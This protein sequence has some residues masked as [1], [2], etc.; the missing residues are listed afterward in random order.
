MA[1]RAAPAAADRDRGYKR[2]L[3]ARYG[4]REYWI[5][6]PQGEMVEV[7]TLVAALPLVTC[8]IPHE[9]KRSY[10]SWL[11]IQNHATVS[12]SNMPSAR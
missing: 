10:S 4:V 8:L 5:V 2:T 11:P 3:Y 9:K 1:E 12:P 6:D 7:F